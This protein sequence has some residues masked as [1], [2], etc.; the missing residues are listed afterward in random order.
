MYTKCTEAS[1][2]EDIVTKE[3]G[4][5]QFMVGRFYIGEHPM[6]FESYIQETSRSGRDGYMASV[7]LYRIYTHTCS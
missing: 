5:L 7:V 6:T 1:I 2:K 3:G 4:R